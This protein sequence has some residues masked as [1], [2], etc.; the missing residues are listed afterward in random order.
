MPK[1]TLLV[2]IPCYGLTQEEIQLRHDLT[3]QLVCQELG[4]SKNDIV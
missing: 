2:V 3:E 1:Y 4:I